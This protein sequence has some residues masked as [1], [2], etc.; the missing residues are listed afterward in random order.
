MQIDGKS[1]EAKACW[2]WSREDFWNCFKWDDK[3]FF[4]YFPFKDKAKSKIVKYDDEYTRYTAW[5]KRKG[6][7]YGRDG[8]KIE[9]GRGEMEEEEE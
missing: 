2:K 6:V 9:H 5:G 7:K 1:I 3:D 4:W 8:V